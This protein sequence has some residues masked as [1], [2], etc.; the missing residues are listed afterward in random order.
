MSGVDAV[1]LSNVAT[2]I[3]AAA[4]TGAVSGDRGV[5][6][7]LLHQ[8]LGVNAGTAHT[9]QVWAIGPLKVA[10]VLVVAFV[11]TRLERR[12]SRR[13]VSAVHFVSPLRAATAR[14]TERAETIAGVVS[15]VFRA[16]IWV[17]AFLTIFSEVGINLTPFV[18]GATVIGA[19]VGFGAQTLVKDFLSGLL[20]L[21]ED[22]YEVGDNIVV[23]S[24]SGTVE[25]VTLRVT[26]IRS[27]DGVVWY[28][29]NGDIRTVGNNSEGDSVALVEV[30]VPLGTDLQRTGRVAEEEARAMADDPQWASCIIGQPNFAGV[31][32]VD[33]GGVTMRV[34]VR[35]GPGQHQRVARELRLRI[36][37]RLR[38]DGLAWVTTP[39][40]NGDAPD[41]APLPADGSGAAPAGS[42]VASQSLDGKHGG[43][44]PEPPAAATPSVAADASRAAAYPATLA[45]ALRRVTRRPKPAT[46]ADGAEDPP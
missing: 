39:A 4:D 27:I 30:V 12:F 44:H 22:Q 46:T 25:G 31:A 10:V 19:A 33:A 35:T 5:I 41:G 3:R 32:S 45:R 18:A 24:T 38:T 37:E 17:I 21:A 6:Y 34:S 36:L 9:V 43:P 28:V 23:G 42:E 40:G 14:G 7:Q 11:L 29:P 1:I 20:I 15:A 13:L 2:G 16:V 26:R 8:D